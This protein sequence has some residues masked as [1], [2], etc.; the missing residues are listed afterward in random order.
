VHSGNYTLDF[1]YTHTHT[2]TH[3]QKT[4][5]CNVCVACMYASLIDIHCKRYLVVDTFQVKRLFV[6]FPC[7]NS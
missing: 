7:N 5:E 2:H 3:T 1:V 6:C 4:C